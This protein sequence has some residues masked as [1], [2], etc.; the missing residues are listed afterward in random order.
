MECVRQ[1]C[2]N[3]SEQNVTQCHHKLSPLKLKVQQFSNGPNRIRW[4]QRELKWAQGQTAYDWTVTYTGCND[5]DPLTYGT[6]T[7]PKAALMYDPLRPHFKGPEE[8][9]PGL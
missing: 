2:T 3:A 8:K 7:T 1:S 4:W 9:Q 6:V 5:Q